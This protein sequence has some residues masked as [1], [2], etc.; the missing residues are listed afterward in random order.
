MRRTTRRKL[1]RA[2]IYALVAGVLIGVALTGK[3]SLDADYDWRWDKLRL[4]SSVV[5]FDN[6]MRNTGG[7]IDDDFL[8]S[9]AQLEYEANEDWTVFGRADI[10]FGE[11]DSP[12]LRLLPRFIAHRNMLGVRWDFAEFHSLTAE[13]ADSSVQ[14]TPTRHDSFNEARL[15]WSFVIQ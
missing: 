3:R 10:G 14:G 4:I 8:L 15:Q 7:D 2:L 6:K 5:Y 13:I 9:Y 11:D 1:I 12:Y